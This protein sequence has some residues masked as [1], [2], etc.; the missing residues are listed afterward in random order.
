MRWTPHSRRRPRT[1]S[2]TWSAMSSGVPAR[3]TLNPLCVGGDEVE[4]PLPGVVGG[5]LELLL[6]A[7][8]EAVR[9]AF[10]L[11]ELVLDAGGG[12]RSVES[13]VRL[14]RDVRVRAGLE[15]ENRPRH[16]RGV[17]DRRAPVE[18]DRA[19][20]PVPRSAREPR[21]GAAHAEADRED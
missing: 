19:H 16:P 4:R 3:P 9:R 20:E 8:E 5:A 10:V 6:L 15:R 21:V 7:V 11:D 2:E 13:G 18:A 14:M 1:K 17:V 12:Q